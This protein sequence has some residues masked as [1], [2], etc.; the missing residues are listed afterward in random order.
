[1][2]R[3]QVWEVE[4]RI[5]GVLTQQGYTGPLSAEYMSNSAPR[6]QSAILGGIN[7]HFYPGGGSNN[8]NICIAN[9]INGIVNSFLLR[10]VPVDSE[11]SQTQFVGAAE[12]PSKNDLLSKALRNAM[13]IAQ[14]SIQAE[15]DT[16]SFRLLLPTEPNY[17][18]AIPQPGSISPSLGQRVGRF[19]SGIIQNVGQAGQEVVTQ[20]TSESYKKQNLLLP[21]RLQQLAGILKE[22]NSSSLGTT[23]TRQPAASA[24]APASRPTAT[25]TARPAAPTPS[26]PN[27]NAMID[28][29]IENARRIA[30]Q[31]TQLA[32]NPAYS[33]N[34]QK[35]QQLAQY[36]TGEFISSMNAAKNAPD[37]ASKLRAIQ[38]I[39][40]P[41]NRGA[42]LRNGLFDLARL[43]ASERR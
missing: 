22:Q 13:D 7:Q 5:L 36:L 4:V 30:P 41:P 11:G 20:I 10:Y 29:A 6:I 27:I 9:T 18:M 15:E 24:P 39:Y 25:A 16:Q 33:A 21:T 23:F 40:T 37:T 8:D 31:V 12:D 34:R 32:S 43:A 42:L 17:N 3:D 1:M 19:L 2:F 26:N 28:R 38:A 14:Q 35:L